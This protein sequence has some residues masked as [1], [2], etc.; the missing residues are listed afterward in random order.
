[1]KKITF[2]TLFLTSFMMF[3]QTTLW[4][5]E[6]PAIVPQFQFGNLGFGNIPNPDPTGNT[7]ARVLEVNKPD[8]A[9]W[10]GGFGFETPGLP[11]I[12]LA[13]GTEFTMDVW[14]PIAGQSIRFQIQNG[15]S[16]EPTYSRDV[17]VPTAGSWV[18]LTFDF[19]VSQPGESINGTEQ[20]AVLV[21]QPNYDPGCEGGS[22]TT[23]GAGNGGIW[24]IDNILQ[25]GVVATCNDGIQN[26]METGV[27]CGGPD[28]PSCPETCSDGIQNQGE[29]GVDCGG[30]NCPPC[31]PDNPTVGPN[32]AA[33]AGTIHYIY[34]ELSGNA[35]SSDFAAFNIV[36]FAGGTQISQPDLS[37][38]T[39]MRIDNLD[40][41]G[42]GFGES[43]NATG[44]YG[45]VHLNYYA[46]T[47]TAFNFSL[48]DQSL[49]T[50]ICCG[51]PQEPF[52]RFGVDAPLVTG[53]WESVFIPLD[54]Y[55]NF[56]ALVDGTWDGTDIIQT[57]ITGNGTVFVDNIF[58]STQNTLSNDEFTNIEFKVFPNPTK[59]NWT[60][61]SNSTV[62]QVQIFDILGKSVLTVNPNQSVSDIDASSLNKGVYFATI[63]TD[64][65]INTVKLVKN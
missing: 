34:S 38:D 7:S 29:T 27:D 56:P 39:V 4:D 5:F 43:F 9:D 64:A 18:N 61:V 1:M 12:N 11:L 32:L 58:F 42:S 15:L 30:P 49:S 22:C 50:T 59:N 45:W 41:F 16:G 40:F 31:P 10:F 19:S 25:L 23:V 54:H 52:F 37:G 62:T 8:T 14:A 63:T 46:T 17:V 55:A 47:S 28:C 36:D 57:L 20:Y 44:T 60:I 33:P 35:N 13:N 26:G 6:N 48:V 65:G 53:S 2:L 51:N 24:Y 3:G 21:I